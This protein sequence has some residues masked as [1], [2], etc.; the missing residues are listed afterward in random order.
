[1][2]HENIN[3]ALKVLKGMRNL[4]AQTKIDIDDAIE[5]KYAVEVAVEALEKQIP[6]KP[7]EKDGWIACPNCEISM[8]GRMYVPWCDNCGQALDWEDEDD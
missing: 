4:I 8:S 1:M 2:M 5:Y 6:K 3:N 7:M